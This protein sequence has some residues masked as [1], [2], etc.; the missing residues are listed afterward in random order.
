MLSQQINSYLLQSSGV[1]YALLAINL[2]L[3]VFAP[4]L[5]TRFSDKELP[6]G[7]RDFR[8]N[9]I[10][11]LNVLVIGLLGHFRF[12]AEGQSGQGIGIKIL[13]ILLIIYLSYLCVHLIG[14]FVRVR[15]GRQ[16]QSVGTSTRIADTYASRALSIFISVFVAVMALISII[17]IAGFSS[18]LE[19]GGVIGF[20]GVFLALTQGAWAPDI[21]S[22]L[23]ILNSKMFKER[24]VIKI[25]DG[26]EEMLAI[27]YRTLAFHTELLNLVDNHRVM[28]KNSRIREHTVH[29]LS[30]FASARGLRETLL[31]KIGYDVS[32]VRVRAMFDAAFQA[33]VEDS[34][35]PIE[36]QHPLEVRLKDTGDHAIEWS[37]HYY[38]KDEFALIK[39]RQLFREKILEASLESGIALST[40]FTVQQHSSSTQTAVSNFASAEEA[41]A[42]QSD[43]AGT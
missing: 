35:I 42:Q 16:V 32:A 31:F 23:V 34:D 2:L 15:F 14:R 20:V 1:L 37:V 28:I 22:G 11:G 5:V 29:N 36:E 43:Q 10:R 6:D 40:P 33:A 30:R 9:V 39:T 12:Y 8:I 4:Y 41:N 38:T 24:D 3:I 19:A 21:I 27:V 13:S 25:T 7:A 17:R 26:G 18:L